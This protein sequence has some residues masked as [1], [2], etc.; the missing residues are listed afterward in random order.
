LPKTFEQPLTFLLAI[1]FLNHY[2]AL[3]SGWCAPGFLSAKKGNL[4][5]NLIEAI[6]R[7]L[8]EPSEAD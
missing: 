5:T 4:K 8:S 3:V 1:L 6:S 2:Y 7:K